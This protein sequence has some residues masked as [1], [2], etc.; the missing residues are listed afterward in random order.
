MKYYVWF[1]GANLDERDGKME[2]KKVA[3]FSQITLPWR[4]RKV[5][6]ITGTWHAFMRE[7]RKMKYEDVAIFLDYRA[8]E[9]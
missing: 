8:V 1:Y 5:I 4:L 6:K 7:K 2:Y 3:L 9:V